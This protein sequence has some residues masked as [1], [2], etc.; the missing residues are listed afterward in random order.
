MRVLT[1]A[2]LVPGLTLSVSAQSTLRSPMAN[3][4][5]ATPVPANAYPYG[6]I[7]FPGGAPSHASALG[8]SISG[9]V[10]YTGVPNYYGGGRPGHGGGFNG[11]NQTV[12]VPYAVPMYAPG[13]GYGDYDYGQQSP[14]NVTVVV[15]QQPTP[16][17]IIN[18]TFSQDG[19]ATRQ[20]LKEY[21]STDRPEEGGL[22][23]YEPGKRSEPVQRRTEQAVPDNQGSAVQRQAD[24]VPSSYVRD[25]QPTIY[26]IALKDT[27]V[28]QAIGYWV[29][30]N[31]LHYVTPQASINHLSLDMVDK[32]L[33]AQLNA[34]RKL[35]LDLRSR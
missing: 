3:P 8:G 18:Q 29:D 28:R 34:E 14:T 1:L 2:V 5:R 16:P 10:P 19:P 35:D 27:T 24:P 12:I 13:A 6:N 4:V 15:P 20:E 23:V 25:G 31:T 17:V 9:T 22:R 32:D 26:L 33:S 30:G 7:L 11:R 21:S